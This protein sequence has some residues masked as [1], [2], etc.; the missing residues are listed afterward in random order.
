M[1]I[2]SVE[3]LALT[4]EALPALRILMRAAA[5]AED[6]GGDPWQ[7]AVELSELEAAGLTRTDLRWLLGKSFATQAQET[8]IPGD[9]ARSFRV[10]APTVRTPGTCL[11]LTP[12]GAARLRMLLDCEAQ[13]SI[14]SQRAHRTSPSSAEPALDLPEWV[15]S[16]RELRFRQTVVKRFRSP[17]PNQELL[18]IAFQ[19]EGWPHQIDDPLIPTSD[20][21]PKPRL[22]ATVKSL[23]RKQLV[24]LLRFHV[25]GNGVQVS[26]EWLNRNGNGENHAL[27][28]RD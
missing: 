24:P 14:T 28:N 2:E 20:Q 9:A 3:G 16:R 21:A 6:V 10:L 26:W 23:N 7:F 19:E 5:Y 4:F 25:G 1:P 17:A 11:Q 27:V 22:T 12:V 8:T 13:T 18:L 15:H